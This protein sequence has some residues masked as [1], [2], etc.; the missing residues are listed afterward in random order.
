MFML[1]FI[2]TC[3]SSSDM[4]MYCPSPVRARWNSAARIAEL[5]LAFVLLAAVC[6]GALV[7]RLVY[8]PLRDLEDGAKRLAAGN[9]DQPIPVRSADELGQAIDFAQDG[10]RLGSGVHDELPS[11]TGEVDEADDSLARP[12]SV[13]ETSRRKSI[14]TDPIGPSSPDA[15]SSATTRGA[16]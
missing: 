2:E 3:T 9:L 1:A 16:G 6:V 13:F 4:S 10:D 15:I 14:A 8:T 5:S 11:S 12:R 7:H